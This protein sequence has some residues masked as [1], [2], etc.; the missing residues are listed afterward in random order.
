VQLR[1][2]PQTPSLAS[3]D[4]TQYLPPRTNQSDAAA[5]RTF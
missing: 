2:I 5:S 4:D 1:E 3:P